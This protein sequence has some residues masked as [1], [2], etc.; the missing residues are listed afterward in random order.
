VVVEEVVVHHL[1]DRGLLP[2]RHIIDG[3]LRVTRMA[4]RNLNF[5]VTT[6]EGQTYLV[7]RSRDGD[8]GIRREAAAYMFLHRVSHASDLTT[9]APAMLASSGPMLVLEYVDGPHLRR[10]HARL[11]RC[12]LALAAQSGMLL[13]AVHA[14]PIANP[15]PALQELVTGDGPRG[16]DVHRPDEQF[17]AESSQAVVQLVALM[18]TDRALCSAL[19]ALAD[20][21]RA[22]TF[23]HCDMRW[24][25]ILVGRQ[26]AGRARLRLVDWETARIG[27]P[28]RDL[29]CLFAEYVSH[30]LWSIPLTTATA[31]ADHARLARYPLEAAQRA[32]R[33]AWASYADRLGI[34]AVDRPDR[35]RRATRFVGLR[36]IERALELDQQSAVMSVA[37]VCHLQTAAGILSDPDCAVTGLLGLPG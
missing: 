19:D 15:P 2:V 11:G 4:G 10:H 5:R 29:G 9:V 22:T 8:E 20:D 34:R 24:D 18:Q 23:T 6:G 25:N 28:D 1:L 21:W 13:A 31:A 30:W 37:A 3:S 14:I 12:P 33:S 16:I 26:E 32:M 35:L 36:L 17:F 7:K 27:D